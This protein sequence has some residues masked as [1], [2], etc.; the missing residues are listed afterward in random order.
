MI[1]LTAKYDFCIY[2]Q[3]YF[4]DNYI[5]LRYKAWYDVLKTKNMIFSK[6]IIF[7]KEKHVWSLSN[8]IMKSRFSCWHF[9]S[10]VGVYG[11]L[12][13]DLFALNTNEI[14]ANTFFWKRHDLLIGKSLK[15]NAEVWERW[16]S[17]NFFLGTKTTKILGALILVSSF[18]LKKWSEI[19][20]VTRWQKIYDT[21]YL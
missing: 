16:N 20:Y 19:Q 13:I 10:K 11:L 12:Y 21:W 9:L 4:L 6:I 15:K 5:F 14:Q 17:W 1:S 3:G 7:L 2:D 8:Q 18:F